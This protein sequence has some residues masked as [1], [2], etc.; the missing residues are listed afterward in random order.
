VFLG[1]GI[2]NSM[3]YSQL[4][5]PARNGHSH[6]SHGQHRRMTKPVNFI[7]AAPGAQSVSICGDFNDWNPNTEVLTRQPDGSWLGQVQLA[8]GSHHYVF[9]VD[10]QAMLDPR[11]QGIARNER[12]ERVSMLM[13]S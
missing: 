12:G 5:T 6:S 3:S 1:L 7:C 10:G 9:V 2:S 4:R 8:H 11:A 13:V